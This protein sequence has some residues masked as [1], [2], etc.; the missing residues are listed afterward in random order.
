MNDYTFNKTKLTNKTIKKTD[1]HFADI[2]QG[3]IDEVLSGEVRVNDKEKYILNNSKRKNEY[4][5]GEANRNNFTY[6]QAA[7]WI[8]TGKCI[9]LL[10]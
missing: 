4:L 5:K 8:Q 2:C 3:C 9:A 1:I 7:Y 10:P 6:L